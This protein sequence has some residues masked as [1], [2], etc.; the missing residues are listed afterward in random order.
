MN[1]IQINELKYN[2]NNIIS[3]DEGDVL[4]IFQG[5]AYPV[6][7]S[8]SSK[9]NIQYLYNL[10]KSLCN[11]F[12]ELKSTF[13]DENGNFR[14]MYLTDNYYRLF[15]AIYNFADRPKLLFGEIINYKDSYAINFEN[16]SNYDIINSKELNDLLKTNI[17][18]Q[19]SYIII[20]GD[21][22]NLEELRNK[23]E[24]FSSKNNIS[25]ILYHG[26]C[27]DFVENIMKNGI[28]Q[29]KE[30]SNFKTE[31]KGYVFLT[32]VFNIADK[33]AAMYAID[34]KSNRAIIKVKSNHLNQNNIVLDYDFSMQYTKD[35]SPFNRT[36][37]DRFIGNVAKNSDK[38][39]TKFAKIGYKGV[40]MPNAIEGVY[41]MTDGEYKFYERK[42]IM[43]N[44]KQKNESI[45]HDI[46]EWKPSFYDEIKNSIKLY[47]GTDIYALED[48]LYDGEI[49][50]LVGK[51]HGETKGVNWFSIKPSENFSRGVLFS[52]EVPKHYFDEHYF[53]F[54][55]DS[56]VISKYGYNIPINQFNFRIEKIGCYTEETF[57]HIFNNI[58]KQDIFEFLKII[59]KTNNELRKI[60]CYIENPI[61][62]TII[63]QFIGEE[64]L[65]KEGFLESTNHLNEVNINDLNLSSFKPK[66]ELNNKFWINNK[67]NSRVRLRLL[68]IADDFIDELAIPSIK[69]KDIVLT[70]SIANFNWSKYSDIDVHIIVNY[71]ELYKDKSFIEDYFNSKKE[72]WS[73]NH[74]D[75]KIYGLPVEI[76]VED[77]NSKTYS[78]GVYSLN[79]NEWIKEPEDFQDAKLNEDYIKEYSAN[80]MNK[81]DNIEKQ[82][83]KEDDNHKIL[84][85]GEKIKKIFNKLKKL[86][87]ESLKT[88]G[89]MSSGNII[90]KLFRRMGYLDKIWDIIYN[91]YNKA[92]SIKE[93]RLYEDYYENS[94]TGKKVWFD[95]EPDIPAEHGGRWNHVKP[96]NDW[97][98]IGIVKDIRNGETKEYVLAN[99]NAEQTDNFQN[100]KSHALSLNNDKKGK[101]GYKY[102]YI[103]SRY[104][105]VELYPEFKDSYY[106]FVLSDGENKKYKNIKHQEL[107]S[108]LFKIGD[109]I[110]LHHDSRYKITDGVI[111]KGK[112]N[113][114]SNNNDWGVY[115]WASRNSGSDPS[116]GQEYTYYCIVNA[117][118]CY[119]IWNN[120]ND[121]KS[122][123]EVYK[124]Y[125]YYLK[126]T[127]GGIACQTAIETPIW[128]IKNNRTGKFYDK[129]WNEIEKPKVL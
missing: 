87:K 98:N 39:G 13:F 86:R 104:Y 91:T 38:N 122:D 124:R 7:L 117:D 119:D 78:S 127:N 58:A 64:W 71:K 77:E 5:Y 69:P 46:N 70:G 82:L 26:T 129:N 16:D 75:L 44:L 99:P 43:N 112:M 84:L 42:Q 14:E 18:E 60:D 90:W 9:E 83:K 72:L 116:N 93:A 36:N 108:M 37:N 120:P 62:M 8:D 65:R 105:T 68:D 121:F 4:I 50:A 123:E 30:N 17:L 115:F 89:E 125:Q 20:N 3:L 85:L 110:I 103:D 51:R 12:T 109:K 59:E 113:S 29:V 66:N 23:I 94:M 54:V 40:V 15:D 96:L 47:H 56:E 21:A 31:N 114:Y 52:I 24:N 10:I 48:I 55:N 101:D 53:E 97:I 11:V 49:N 74:D 33:Y 1:P 100:F 6:F 41:I 107:S 19:F 32:S 102:F 67:L 2:I 35:E 63:K 81:I 73:N 45:K 92:N 88:K 34:R 118:K 76:Y 57:K 22:F 128:C 111:K 27:T 95:N 61:I 106:D 25:N 79:K 28:R 126:E 80:L